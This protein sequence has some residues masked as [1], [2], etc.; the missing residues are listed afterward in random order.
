MVSA[1]L[2]CEV[3]TIPLLEVHMRSF[4]LQDHEQNVAPMTE[5]QRIKVAHMRALAEDKRRDALRAYKI[6]AK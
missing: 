6:A 2:C 1:I 3:F 4:F 5:A